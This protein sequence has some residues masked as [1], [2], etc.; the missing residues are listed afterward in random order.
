MSSLK[1]FEN[2]AQLIRHISEETGR[3]ENELW[4]ELD[5]KLK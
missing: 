3:P 2:H 4:D 5:E 1:R